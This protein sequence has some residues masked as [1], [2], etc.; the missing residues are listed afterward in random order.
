LDKV[1]RVN[2]F[3]VSNVS[4]N[5]VTLFDAIEQVSQL[6]DSETYTQLFQGVNVRIER[7][8]RNNGF[9]E[10][11]LVRQQTDNLPPIA[12][13]DRPLA[14]NTNPLGHRSAFCYYPRLNII[15]LEANRQG[16]SPS[17][18]NAFLRRR[19]GTHRGFFF[20]P[21]LNEDAMSQLRDGTPRQLQLRVASPSDLRSIEGSPYDIEGNLGR[22]QDMVGG[23]TVSVEVGF[24]RGDRDGSL[25]LRSLTELSRWAFGNRGQ[26]KKIAVKTLEDDVPIDLFGQQIFERETLDLD[27]E[28]LDEAYSVRIMFLRTSFEQRMREIVRLYGN[29]DN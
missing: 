2:F 1:V 19:L 22:L 5:D 11:D 17:R 7:V 8:G 27:T 3:Q 4:A 10:G 16:T 15:A 29:G 21:C 26:V 28:D 23:Q 14:V 20:D 13:A 25:N 12:H 9:L 24:G 6:P 18:L